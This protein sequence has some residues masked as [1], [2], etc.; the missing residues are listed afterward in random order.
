MRLRVACVETDEDTLTALCADAANHFGMD[1]RPVR[2]HELAA[3]ETGRGGV[4]D[5]VPD[6]L[7][8]ADVLITTAYH[9][10]EVRRAAGR[11]GKPMLV[12]GV[13]PGHARAVEERLRQRELTVVCVDARFG[14]R[15][16][17]MRGGRYA[18]RVRVVL[19]DDAAALAT[20]DPPSRCS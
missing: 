12:A 1:A 20:L 17:A 3:E 11:L 7:R 9:A 2:P 18:S 5:G 15:V 16:R 4:H 13:N 6:A 14:E 8:D 19:A 10:A